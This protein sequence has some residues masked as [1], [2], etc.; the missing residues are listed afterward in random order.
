MNETKKYL[1]VVFDLFGTLV[2]NFSYQAY[3]D[4]LSQMASALLLSSDDFRQV[5]FA[6]SKERNS[7]IAQSCEGDIRNVCRALGMLPEDSQVQLAVQRRLDYIR[8]VMTPQPDAIEVLVRLKEEGFGI[9][10]LSN[11]THEI[12]T[13]W[14]ETPFAPLIDVA[15][16]SCSVGMMKPNPRIYELTAE[17]LEVRP[18]ECLFIGDGGSQE[19]SGALSVGML[20]VLTRP[21]ADSMEPHLRNREQWDGLTISS[22][23]DILAVLKEIGD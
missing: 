11:C 22:L 10:L 18:E 14:S 20:P 7:G 9:G 4:S 13:V 21:D 17:R 8:S 2:H 1:A 5:W 15:I 12:P 3:N 19:L 23:M 16:F 6:T